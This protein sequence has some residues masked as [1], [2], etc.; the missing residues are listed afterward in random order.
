MSKGYRI[1]YSEETAR[2]FFEKI[3]NNGDCE[4]IALSE[5]VLKHLP[6]TIDDYHLMCY[7]QTKKDE[8]TIFIIY[9]N[10]NWGTFHRKY[11]MCSSIN[12]GDNIDQVVSVL[13]EQIKLSYNIVKQRVKI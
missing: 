7:T 11:G 10:Y 12:D 13:A 8:T 9:L 3:N 5:K 4:F 1:P 2:I 6:T